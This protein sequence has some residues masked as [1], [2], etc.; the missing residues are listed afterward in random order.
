MRTHVLLDPSQ[1]GLDARS[2]TLAPLAYLADAPRW[3]GG[4]Q[5]LPPC[6]THERMAVARWAG[7][8]TKALDEYFLSNFLKYS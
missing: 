6:L 8:Q 2:L 4:E 5:I 3:G 7:R 1:G